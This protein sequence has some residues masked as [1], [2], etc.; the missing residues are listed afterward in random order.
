MTTRTYDGLSA[1]ELAGFRQ[2]QH[3]HMP[4]RC[5]RFKRTPAADGIG[6]Q[7]TGYTDE[8]Q[9][10]CRIGVPSRAEQETAA[11]RFKSTPRAILTLEWDTDAVV[12]DRVRVDTGTQAGVLVDLIGRLSTFE[13]WETCARF[14]VLDVAD[15]ARPAQVP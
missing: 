7:T 13:S 1:G 9:R 14:A 3:D 4:D 10:D 6:G 2:T 8:G 15:D 12:G 5:T 11:D